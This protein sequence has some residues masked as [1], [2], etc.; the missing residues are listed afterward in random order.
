M[1]KT[2]RSATY[3]LQVGSRKDGSARFFKYSGIV[4]NVGCS[5]SG[6][7]AE[8]EQDKG[9]DAA[10]E[11]LRNKGVD[12][13]ARQKAV[14]RLNTW[15]QAKEGKVSDKAVFSTI[16]AAGADF[17]AY[18]AEKGGD[19]L[20]AGKKYL[21][22]NTKNAENCPLDEVSEDEADVIKK[23]R[24]E[25]WKKVTGKVEKDESDEKGESDK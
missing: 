19:L 23:A 20:E 1:P 21:A 14:H 6:M 15:E 8:L 25:E 10:W 11:I 24:S 4:P 22:E 16:A 9:K 18:W 17:Q 12:L 3:V 13:W 5:P 7:L 2:Y